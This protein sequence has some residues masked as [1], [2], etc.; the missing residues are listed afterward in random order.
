MASS[1]QAAEELMSK[2]RELQGMYDRP[3]KRCGELEKKNT[4]LPGGKIEQS[5]APGREFTGSSNTK[6]SYFMRAGVGDW[7]HVA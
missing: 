3:R 4:E 1:G 2:Y 5:G 7:A 6:T